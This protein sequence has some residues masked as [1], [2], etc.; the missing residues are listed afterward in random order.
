MLVFFEGRNSVYLMGPIYSL[1][2]CITVGFL[3]AIPASY[4]TRFKFYK[5]LF[6]K[7]FEKY[8]AADQ[9]Q[10]GKGAD[11]LIRGMMTVIVI[12]SVVL[13][14]FLAKWNVNFLEDGI[15]D[16]SKFLSLKGEYY[17]YADIDRVYYKPDRV[18]S[19]GETLN[20]PSYVIV[21]RDGKEIDLY[22]FDEI[23]RYE[24]RL[25]SF[26]REKGVKVESSQTE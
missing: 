23:E 9:V 5:L 11:K 1:P 13:S 24:D 7:D 6:P 10:N 25:L 12:G 22:E 2:Y 4:F 8:C 18:N 3:T 15:V 14:I 20:Y 26:L 21:L 19:F 16:N 17:D